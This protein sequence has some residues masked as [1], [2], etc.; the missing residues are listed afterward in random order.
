LLQRHSR[1]RMSYSEIECDRRLLLRDKPFY[2]NTGGGVTVS[3][4][5]PTVQYPFLHEL[6]RLLKQ[7]GVHTA[8]E[9]CG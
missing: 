3:G 9:T 8:L 5:E 4:G 1:L 2:D 6:L 7:R